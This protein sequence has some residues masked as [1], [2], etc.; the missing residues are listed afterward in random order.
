M[1]IKTEKQIKLKTGEVL[2]K[3][4]PVEFIPSRNSVC[5]VIA[6]CGREYMVRITSAFI[7]P[8]MDE[9]DEAMCDG[10]CMSVAGETIEPDGHDEHGSPSW[11]LVFGLI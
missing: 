11:L 8:S 10:V 5:R 2:P 4:L 6:G 7:T 3:G 9:I 1:S